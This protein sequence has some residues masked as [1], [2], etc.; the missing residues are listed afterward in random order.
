[1][2]NIRKILIWGTEKLN[3]QKINS[4]FL[5]A[6]LL[7]SLVIKKPREYLYT[8]PEFKL[9]KKQIKNYKKLILQ[10]ATHYPLAYIFGYKEFY[11]LKFKVNQ[12]VLIPRP[13]TETLV[14]ATL[15]VTRLAEASAKRVAK[16]GDPEGRLR[17]A[18]IGTGSGCISIA[19]IKNGIKKI[20]ATD[21]SSQALKIA[22]AN[23]KS[24]QV[25][26]KIQFIRG[27]LLTP[28]KNKQI[29][30]IIAN[31]PY[32]DTNYKYLIKNSD[33]L[34]LRYEPIEALQGGKN[35]LYYYQKLFQQASELKYQPKYILLELDPQQIKPLTKYIQ[36][37]YPQAKSPQLKNKCGD[38]IQIKKDHVIQH[39]KPSGLDRVII[40]KLK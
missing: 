35:G 31:L 40:V 18:E 37:I 15:R 24:Q 22:K 39:G 26:S 16:W 30:I 19:L 14:E 36:K 17:L 33:Q 5:D 34:S 38:K 4:A 23:A 3:D 32:L 9:N 13:E 6:E 25:L 10:R 20:I 12:H 21:I 1:M 28:L 7:L 29:E 8:Y 11:G 2:N 27:N